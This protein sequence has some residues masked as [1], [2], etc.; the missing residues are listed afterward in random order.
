MFDTLFWYTGLFVWTTS[1][2]VI[3]F[4]SLHLTLSAIYATIITALQYIRAK[5]IKLPKNK[6]GITLWNFWKQEFFWGSLKEQ[7]LAVVKCWKN[8]I[9]D[10]DGKDRT[11]VFVKNK[12]K[13]ENGFYRQ[14]LVEKWTLNEKK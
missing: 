11:L 8:M 1:A 7:R 13:D 4:V 2:F 14:I 10:W 3:I 5:R 12:T 6:W 9:R